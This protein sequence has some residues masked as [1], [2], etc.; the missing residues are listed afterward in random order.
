MDD[1]DI[2]KND[3]ND[4]NP[5]SIIS[6]TALYDTGN[7]DDNYTVRTITEVTYENTVYKVPGKEEHSLI[8]LSYDKKSPFTIDQHEIQHYS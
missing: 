2:Y 3:N 5:V 8:K 6:T 1:D 4:A 7:T